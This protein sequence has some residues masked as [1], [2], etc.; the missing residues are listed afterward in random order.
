MINVRNNNYY[1]NL[2]IMKD[3]SLDTTCKDS[4]D[5]AGINI[6]NVWGNNFSLRFSEFCACASEKLKRTYFSR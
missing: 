2:V 6:E 5:R 4:L 3:C 1:I